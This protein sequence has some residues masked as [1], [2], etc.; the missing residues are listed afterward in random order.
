MV[1]ED[2]TRTGGQAASAAEP[3]L[4]VVNQPTNQ[5]I[6]FIWNSI[7]NISS[8]VHRG[9]SSVPEIEHVLAEIQKTQFTTKIIKIRHLDKIKISYFSCET[10][11]SD[12]MTTYP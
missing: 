1:K 11:C 9:T 10:D 2:N 4:A 6:D 7:Q 12:H 5:E 8:K 3:D